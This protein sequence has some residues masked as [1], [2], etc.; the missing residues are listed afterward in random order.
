MSSYWVN[1]ARSGDPNGS[2]LP[3]WPAYSA[4]G[5]G[6]AMVL[7]DRVGP[8]AA[9]TPAA[10]TLDFFDAAYARLLAGGTQ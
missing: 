5:I 9:T 2:G 3:E 8:E 6:R 1:F 10:K 4:D 7:G